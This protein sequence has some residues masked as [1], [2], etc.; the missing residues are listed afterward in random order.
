MEPEIKSRISLNPSTLLAPVP[1][2]LISCRGTGKDD[3]PNLITLAW[4]GT[5]C[6]DPPMVS[7]SIRKSRFSHHLIVE[8]GEFIVNLVDEALLKATD[9]CGVKSGRDIDKFAECHL[10]AI[11]APGMDYAPAVEE[12]P[13]SMSCKVR[14]VLELGAHDCFIGEIVAVTARPSLIDKEQ[15]L[16]LDKANLVAYC[17]GDYYALGHLLGFYGYSV[18][19]PEVLARRMPKP[20]KTAVRVNHAASRQPPVKKSRA[21]RPSEGRSP[22]GK[23]QN[24]PG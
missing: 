11:P 15:K 1:T 23:N 10:T 13:L 8:S 21:A 3:Q 19:S 6:S 22:R 16:R 7:V 20:G 24:N 18:A 17:H 2:A 9:F 5:V 4:V 12:S 14:Q